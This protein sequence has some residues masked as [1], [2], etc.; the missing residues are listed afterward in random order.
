MATDFSVFYV[1]E[2]SPLS[3]LGIFSKL[4][5]QRVLERLPVVLGPAA[6]GWQGSEGH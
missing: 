2:A 3:S 5:P 1:L 6:A 4:M